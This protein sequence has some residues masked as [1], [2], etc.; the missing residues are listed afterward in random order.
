MTTDSFGEQVAARYGRG[1]MFSPEALVPTVG[2]SDLR[3]PLW[4]EAGDVG[5]HGL[6]RDRRR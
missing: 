5:R 6:K 1:P 4:N 3:R 2:F